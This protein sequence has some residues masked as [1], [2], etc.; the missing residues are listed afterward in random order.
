M[1]EGVSEVSE[2]A[3]EW[4]VRANK[5]PSIFVGILAHSGPQCLGDAVKIK[6]KTKI[7]ID[8]WNIF[9][10]DADIAGGWGMWKRSRG[11]LSRSG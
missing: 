1:S 9:I 6:K 7:L 3:N 10:L 4:M 5:W 8:D 11:C 2:Q